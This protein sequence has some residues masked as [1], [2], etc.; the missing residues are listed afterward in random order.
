MFKDQNVNPHGLER[1]IDPP[2][3]V[4][5]DDKVVGGLADYIVAHTIKEILAEPDNFIDLF[6][7]LMDTS[8]LNESDEDTIEATLEAIT[9]GPHIE[10]VCNAIQDM[11]EKAYPEPPL[12]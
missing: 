8:I 5:P 3:Y 1:P 4:E 10:S 7:D 12:D 2:V 11:I 6:R 9:C